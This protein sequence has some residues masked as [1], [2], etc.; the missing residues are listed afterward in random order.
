M[1]IKTLEALGI[2]AEA[3]GE[4]I[5]EQC[6]ETLLNSTGFNPETE[7]ETRYASR[8]QREISDRI[9]KAV[10]VKIAALAEE[11][12]LPRV[13]ELIE[14]ADMRRTNGYGEAKGPTMTFKEYLAWRTDTYMTEDVDFHGKSKADLEARGESTY[15]WRSCGP[16]LTVLM[17]NYILDTMEKHAKAAITDVNQVIAKGMEKAA[18]EA[19]TS[20][21][22]AVKV[23]ITA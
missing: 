20:A 16:R 14:K 11:H 12:L 8:F 6:V 22:A 3:L 10:D 15:N 23:S 13:G 1:D 7:E 19:I 9:Q 18:R 5:V 4:R 2:S 17:R 21:A